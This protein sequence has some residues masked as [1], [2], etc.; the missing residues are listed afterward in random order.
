[1][2]T[3]TPSPLHLSRIGRWPCRHLVVRVA[4]ACLASR[5]TGAFLLAIAAVLAVK[6]GAVADVPW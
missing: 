6:A 2:T 4:R 1:M 5:E 3:A